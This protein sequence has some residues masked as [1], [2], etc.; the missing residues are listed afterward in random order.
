MI[1]AA[2]V[3]LEKFPLTPNGKIDRRALPAPDTIQQPEENTALALTPVQE[4]LTGIWADILG[5][6][7]VG[8]LRQ[9]L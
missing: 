1:P 7:Q 9:L 3:V 6:K 8:H 4:M 2:F 5:I